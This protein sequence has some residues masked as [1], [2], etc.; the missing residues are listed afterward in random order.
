MKNSKKILMASFFMLC[1]CALSL[2]LVI[3]TDYQAEGFVKVISMVISLLFW[4]SLL[5]GYILM[6]LFYQKNPD[7]KLKGKIGIISFFTN[8]F[9]VITDLVMFASIIFM[10]VLSLLNVY[11]NVIYAL[12]FSILFISLNF[13]CVFNGKVFNKMI[14]EKGG[15]KN[16]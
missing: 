6:I 13:H 16:E 12:L 15:N 10:I 9:A 11:F 1:L 4:I 5:A 7:K 8:K 14:I 3:F 2:F